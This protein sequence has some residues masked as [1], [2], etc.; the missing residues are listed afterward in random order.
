MGDLNIE[1]HC[2][3]DF[4]SRGQRISLSLLLVTRSNFLA[5]PRVSCG[6]FRAQFIFMQASSFLQ[7]IFLEMRVVF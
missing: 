1:E 4:D 3:W 6:A 2:S 7:F 5:T